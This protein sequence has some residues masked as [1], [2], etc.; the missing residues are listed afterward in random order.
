MAV[1]RLL[2]ITAL[3]I[4]LVFFTAYQEWLSWLLLLVILGLPVLSLVVSLPAMLGFRAEPVVP[5]AA[6]M[7]IRVDT[8]LTGWC[9]LPVPPFQGRLRI[10]RSITGQQWQIKSGGALP[11][12]HCGGLTAAPEKV[13][14]YDYLGLIGI[15]VRNKET[16]TVVVRP[17]PVEIPQLPDLDRFLARSWRPKFGGGYAENHELRLYRPGDSLNQVHWKL[18][19][20]TGKLILREPMQP[21]RGLVLVTM[22]LRGTPEELDRKFGRLLW[23]GSHL[24]EKEVTFEIRTLTGQGVLCRSV[25]SQQT[26]AKAMDELLCAGP[27]IEGDLRE[28]QFRA[29]W[30]YHIGGGPDEA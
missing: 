20:K 30:Q 21:E 11:T 4:G 9:R 24:L 25:E 18:S 26:L 1:R 3:G 15:P 2:Y 6:R 12:D 27:A 14:V 16:K 23:L 28:R 10:C 8:R 19:A 13:W 5:A 22:N 7:G 29:S 17:V